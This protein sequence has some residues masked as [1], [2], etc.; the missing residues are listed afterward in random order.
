MPIGAADLRLHFDRIP[1][2]APSTVSDRP[3]NDGGSLDRLSRVSIDNLTFY[4]RA[5]IG[6]PRAGNETGK[7]HCQNSS[8][9]SP[10]GITHSAGLF[11]HTPCRS[12]GSRRAD[13]LSFRACGHS[14][15]PPRPSDVVGNCP[16]GGD[17]RQ[18]AEAA[19]AAKRRGMPWR[20]CQSSAPGCSRR[21]RWSPTSR[22]CLC[23]S[24]FWV[25]S[26]VS[27]GYGSSGARVS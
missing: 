25:G 12:P 3:K 7:R 10:L 16:F 13:P 20:H 21:L 23:P 2:H 15:C 8:T 26:R 27:W 11:C 5:T 24:F 9:H 18:R 22:E 1:F 6:L 17:P 14:P 4:R 19:T